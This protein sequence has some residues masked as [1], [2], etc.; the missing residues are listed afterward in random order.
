MTPAVLSIII[1]FVV[2][3]LFIWN[4]LPTA[5]VALLGLVAVV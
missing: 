2:V 5:T 4:K 3:V 1:F